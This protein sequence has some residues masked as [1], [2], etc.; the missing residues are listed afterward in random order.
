[1]ALA[2]DRDGV[3]WLGSEEY[4]FQGLERIAERGAGSE[5]PPSSERLSVEFVRGS[6]MGGGIGSKLRQLRF[7]SDTFDKIVVCGRQAP[8]PGCPV[9]CVRSAVPEAH[10]T[11]FVLNAFSH[12]MYFVF[13]TMICLCILW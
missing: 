6:G 7:K 13:K 4:S 2:A 11:F 3:L 9:A 8:K 1:M 12:S 10:I 5:E